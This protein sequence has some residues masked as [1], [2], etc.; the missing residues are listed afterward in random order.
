MIKSL[1]IVYPIFNE[2]NRL[3]N[4]FL[5]IKKFNKKT[6]YINKEY[7]FVDDG[8]IDKSKLILENFIKKNLNKKIDYRIVSCNKNKGKGYALKRGVNKSS[9]KW[10]LTSDADCSVSNFQLIEWLKKDYIS[11]KNKIYF[12][13]RNHPSSKVKKIKIRELIGGLFRLF[14]N[15]FFEVKISDT[16][17]GFK[18][19]SSLEGKKV[20]NKIKTNGYMHDLEIYLIAK[21]MMIDIKELPV[22]WKHKPEGKIRFLKDFVK[23]FF[24][25]IKIKFYKY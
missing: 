24:S 10:I 22:N 6:K 2:E 11:I 23:I 12:S 21:K 8:S 25:L 5:D 3:V 18:L 7:I 13:S 20:F 15:M 1:S 19:Y 14:I 17:C 4:I 9:K 16:Q